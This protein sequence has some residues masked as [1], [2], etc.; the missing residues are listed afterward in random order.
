[1]LT[2][3]ELGAFIKEMRRKNGWTQKQLAEKL[4]VTDKAVSRWERGLGFPDIQ[5]LEPLSEA[6]EVS[7]QELIS[8]KKTPQSET[9]D[10]SPLEGQ[11]KPRNPSQSET[12]SQ[13]AQSSIQEVIDNFEEARTQYQRKVKKRKRIICSFLIFLQILCF[14]WFVPFPQ[15]VSHTL[16]G[17]IHLPDGTKAPVTVE[18]KGFLWHYFFEGNPFKHTFSWHE[19]GFHGDMTFVADT[20]DNGCVTWY[21]TGTRSAYGNNRP[22]WLMRF[23]PEPEEIIFLRWQYLNADGGSDEFRISPDFTRIVIMNSASLDGAAIVAAEDPYTDY[24]KLFDIYCD[25]LK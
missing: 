7:M 1:M 4:M 24:Q 17:Q 6:L 2:P 13:P 21:F 11:E 9:T 18:I 25:L 8:A 5:F 20:L 12:V 10:L 3:K 19:R 23:P 16:T 14:V 22:G 15:R